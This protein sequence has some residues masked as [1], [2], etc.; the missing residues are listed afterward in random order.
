LGHATVKDTADSELVCP[1]VILIRTARAI[2]ITVFV[3][4]FIV[5]PV[6][7]FLTLTV[8][9]L[10]L[11]VVIAFIRVIVWRV[12]IAHIIVVIFVTLGELTAERCMSAGV[13]IDHIAP[14]E[15]RDVA[16]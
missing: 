13:K 11:I 5:I 1:C 15:R 6:E 14:R 3:R 10:F 8:A 2:V 12:F 9:T 7:T 4:A 16:E